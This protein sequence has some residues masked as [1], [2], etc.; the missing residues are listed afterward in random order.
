MGRPPSSEDVTAAVKF[1][2]SDGADYITGQVINVTG[3]WML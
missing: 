1:F 2:A 3:G